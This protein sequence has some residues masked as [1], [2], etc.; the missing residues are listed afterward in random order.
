LHGFR[1]WRQDPTRDADEAGMSRDVVVS[2]AL[3]LQCLIDYISDV[4][5]VDRSQVVGEILKPPPEQLAEM[6]ESITAF[7]RSS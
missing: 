4:R 5:R 1:V 3:H 2:L 6:Y 7:V